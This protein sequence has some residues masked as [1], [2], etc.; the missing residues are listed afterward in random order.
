M[1]LAEHAPERTPRFPYQTK[2][3][4]C[5]A[6]VGKADGHEQKG[7]KMNQIVRRNRTDHTS[8][9]RKLTQIS[10]DSFKGTLRTQEGHWEQKVHLT[11]NTS[12]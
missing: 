9:S 11:K 3:Q 6:R 2:E 5:V 12:S 10:W 8:T 7:Q 4:N 1:L